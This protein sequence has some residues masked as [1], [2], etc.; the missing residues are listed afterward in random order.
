[1]NIKE[2]VLDKNLAYVACNLCGSRH[3]KILL[4]STLKEDDFKNSH[5]QYTISERGHAYCQI[6]QCERC[7]LVYANPRDNDRDIINNYTMVE[8]EKYLGEWKAREAVFS[9]KLRLIEKYAAK[10]GRLLDLGCFAGIFLNLVRR[11]NWSILGIEPSKWAA[12]YGR[13]ELNLEILQGTLEDFIFND[14]TFD[15][16]TMW[17]VIE[18]L[19]DPKSTLSLLNKKLKKGGMLYLTTPNFDSIYRKLFGKRYWFIERMHIYYF[20]PGTIRRMLEESNYEVIEIGLNFKTMSMGYF[21][22]RLKEVSKFLTKIIIILSLLFLLGKRDITVY[23]GEMT[24][25]AKKR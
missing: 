10:K 22:F 8:D 18:H 15:V 9:R 1:M 25:I 20:T 14:E 3:Y 6:V 12:N 7:N 21:I 13:N 4:R 19:P 23:A 11:K 24:I 2:A 5:I 16:V 17:D